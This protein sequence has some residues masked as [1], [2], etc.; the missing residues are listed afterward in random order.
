MNI[1][2]RKEAKQQ[3]LTRYFTGVPCPKGH[4]AEK[5][6]S[7]YSCIVCIKHK[8]NLWNQ[9]NKQKNQS[10]KNN[11][12]RRN[13]DS[14]L[15]NTRKYQTNKKQRLPKWINEDELWMIKEAYHL[16]KLR[17]KATGIP[18]QVDHIIPL[19]GKTVTGFHTINNLQVICKRENRLKSNNWD[20]DNQK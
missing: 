9:N 15:F 14:M 19:Q 3:S 16:C 12:V 7:N 6:V 18:H 17:T 1:I 2:T 11:W 13:K 8:A 20:W 10:Y 5:L 4:I